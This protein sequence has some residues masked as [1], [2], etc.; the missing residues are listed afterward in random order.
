MASSQR[1]L[2]MPDGYLLVAYLLEVVCIRPR[3]ATRIYLASL[4]KTP[5]YIY[6]YIYT[7][8]WVL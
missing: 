8:W 4:S 1:L 2:D 5:I 7:E 3:K 6:V